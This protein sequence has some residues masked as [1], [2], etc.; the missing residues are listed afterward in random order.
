MTVNA[1]SNSR[2][3]GPDVIQPLART[4]PTAAIVAAS[5]VGRVSLL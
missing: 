1:A 2:T 4:S 3:F 5:M